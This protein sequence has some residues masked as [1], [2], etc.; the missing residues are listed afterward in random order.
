MQ[1]R[2]KTGGPKGRSSQ[3]KKLAVKIHEGHRDV[4]PGEDLT[5]LELHIGSW[6]VNGLK[7]R[8]AELIRDLEAQNIHLC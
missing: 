7:K 1:S 6:N 8:E 3:G 4:S 2:Q 5:K